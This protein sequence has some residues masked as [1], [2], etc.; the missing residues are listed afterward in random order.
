[1]SW[2]KD[3]FSTW[4]M[5]TSD[6]MSRIDNQSSNVLNQS[7]MRAQDPR[8]SGE[9]HIGLVLDSAASAYYSIVR[10]RGGA[11]LTCV[12]LGTNSL[13]YGVNE[14]NLPAEGS[15]VFVHKPC[16]DADYGII[17]GCVPA[18]ESTSSAGDEAAA[19]SYS[20]LWDIE[21]SATGSTELAHDKPIADPQDVR[22]MEA[23]ATRA[24]DAFP[25]DWLMLNDRDVGIMVGRFMASLHGSDRARVDVSLVDDLVRIIAGYLRII[26]AQGETQTLNDGGYPSTW[27]SA[28]S[29][30]CEKS[31]FKHY[32]SPI[33]VDTGIDVHLPRSTT[34]RYQMVIGDLMSK[35]RLQVFT[36]WLGDMVDMFVAKPDPAANPERYSNN[37]K[38]QGLCHM[39]VDACG[40]MVVR[41]AAGI[42]LQ[43]WDRIPIPKQKY[44]LWDPEGDKI[45]ESYTPEEKKPVDWPDDHKYGR[46]LQIRDGYAWIHKMGYR[47]LHDQ[48][49]QGG[50]KD[51]YLPD[52]DELIT[53]DVL[54]DE[55]GKAEEDY[56]KNDLRQSYVNI[57][58]DGS[59]IMRDT[60]GSE[61]VMR[62][63]NIIFN[64][65]GQIEVRP[66]KSLV[67]LAGDDLVAKA[68]NSVDITATD[69]DVRIKADGNLHLLSEARNN[70][71][72][73]GVLIESKSPSEGVMFDALKGEDVVSRGIILRAEKSTI[74]SQGKTV[75]STAERCHKIECFG[76]DDGNDG[77]ILLSGR[78]LTSN[79]KQQTLLTTDK[80]A[81][82]L[83]GRNQAML[84]GR[85]AMLVAKRSVA[86]LKDSKAWIPF[87][88]IPIPV[89]VYDS[90]QPLIEMTYDFLQDTPWLTP[91]LPDMRA[92]IEFTY[93][94]SQQYNT[95]VP[96]EIHEAT[97]FYVYQAS[98][99]YLKD[100]G[101]HTLTGVNKTTWTEFPI[102]DTWPWPGE[103]HYLGGTAYVKLIDEV[104]I[105]DPATGIPKKRESV[106]EAVGTFNTVDF[107]QY[108]IVI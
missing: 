81:A 47:R 104:N 56:P 85:S 42:S 5:N 87:M 26:N 24:L 11:D 61:I 46:S 6:K 1:M 76:E 32:G 51:I 8:N 23:N 82:C 103:E 50:H 9:F 31:G 66:G 28:T 35:R 37:S 12:T 33:A 14:S 53:P 27:L 77:Q 25:G 7:Q 73:G 41:S 69:E 21:P 52:E 22:C 102:S 10:L 90:I 65:P 29:H 84:V 55:L 40:R 108:E 30:Q 70:S 93:R 2:I 15:Y 95:M 49:V 94:T 71:S 4:Q 62:G 48:S 92:D 43:R 96:S 38:D 106:T 34:S 89:D 67:M 60:W 19:W 97:A 36:G 107:N 101:F 20:A 100:V 57:E 44:E 74:F 88:E 13:I 3:V 63:G 17:L 86:I 99:A 16:A 75:H 64:C 39:H 18:F 72:K 105:E 98:W 80:Y 58:D 91:F 68:K 59:I 45:E 83:I 54:Y 78:K 79:M